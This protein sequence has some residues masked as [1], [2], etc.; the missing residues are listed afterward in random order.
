M[1]TALTVAGSD[2]TGGAGLQADLKVFRAFGIHGL[3]VLSAITAQNSEGVDAV[4]PVDL[5]FIEKQ[6]H[7]LLT[8]IKPQAVKLGMLYKTTAVKIVAEVLKKY[9]LGN[10]V[11]DPVI[12]SSSGT[13][14]VEDGMLDVMI[15]ALFPLSKLITPNIHEA[16]VLSGMVIKNE[17]DIKD[18]V[19]KLKEMG[20]EA[21]VITGGHLNETAS[22]IFY[23]GEFHVLEGSKMEGE[24]HGTGCV[25]SSGITA[26]LALDY[27]TLEAVKR[28][29]EFVR[30]A[31]EK[32]YCPG[33]G[34]AFLHI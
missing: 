14:L 12:I 32:A 33:K 23:D 10:L 13:K 16:S 21:V 30:R 34:M 20:P 7:T 29:K 31:M 15:D 24:Y 19:K 25:F 17:K 2:P 27:S 22:D 28:A 6:F 3:A 9:S 18:A 26:L 1:K 5:D 4:L 11:I 8:D